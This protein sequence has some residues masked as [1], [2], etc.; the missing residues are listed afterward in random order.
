[1]S[2]TCQAAVMHTAGQPMKIREIRLAPPRYGEVLVRTGAAGICGTDLFFAAGRF[3]YSTPTVLGHEA[4]GT[5]EAVG[6][7]VTAFTPGDRVIV[8]D[9]T[10]CGTCSACLSGR[11]VYCVD[12][13]AK[14]RQRE[15]LSL[16]GGP[17]RQYLGVS[18]FAERMV[19]DEHALIPLPDSISFAAGALL[20]CC[21]TTG[22]ATVF[23]VARPTPGSSVA[24]IGT[25]GVGLGAVQ[26]ARIAGASRIIAVDLHEHRLQVAKEVGATDVVLAG[27]QDT[28]EAITQLTGTGVDHAVEAVGLTETAAQAFKS[29]APGGQATV[30]GMMPPGA[31]ISVPGRLIRQGR[32]LAGTVMGSVRTRTDIPRYADLLMRG[33]LHADPLIT[34]SRPLKDINEAFKDATARVGVRSL[35]SF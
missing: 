24:V 18:A 4:A 28:A 34:S 11:M 27:P 32:S 25:G 13:S 2:L 35:I 9:Q 17:V 16:N 15:R 12:T 1:M 33:T 29:L 6:D 8:C 26:G 30:I 20:S 19:V 10:F 14:Q 7:G 23:N 31:E 21:L 5:V 22:L 3:P